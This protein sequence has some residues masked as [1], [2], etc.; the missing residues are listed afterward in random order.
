MKRPFAIWISALGICAG[1]LRLDAQTNQFFYDNS[2]RLS[3]VISTNGTDA[4]FYDYDAVGNIVTIRRQAVGP[5]NLFTY[6][7]ETAT[8]LNPLTLQGTGFST[9]PALNTVVFCGTIT[10]QV[11]SATATQLKVLAPTNAVNCLIVIT[12]PSGTTTNSRAFT[13]GVGVVISPSSITMSG[14][15]QQQFAAIVGGTTNQ[16]VTWNINGWI[17]AGTNTAWGMISAGGLYTSPTNPPPGGIV[18]VR[19][20]S[21]AASDSFG[22]G[23]ATITV[24]SPRGP[25]YSP[26][27]SAQPGTPIILGPVY[28]VTV[29]AQPGVPIVLGPI[30]SPTVSAGPSP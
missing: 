13:T 7:P 23:V 25:I 5:V 17:P 20:H 15:F 2:G 29:S 19:A 21:V 8:G 28:S 14:T 16:S 11:V 3:V 18:N 22:D 12:T 6:S 4:A 26:T 10:A 9:N 27:V 30:Y 1:S 24:L